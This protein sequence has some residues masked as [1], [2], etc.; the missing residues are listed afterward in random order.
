MASYRKW[1]A[2][3]NSAADEYEKTVRWME[4]AL[5]PPTLEWM[6]ATGRKALIANV[7]R[8]LG[9]K[10]RS[11]AECER[12]AASDKAMAFPPE[13]DMTRGPSALV[14]DADVAAP[15]PGFNRL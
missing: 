1:R 6:S 10:I 4:Q 14:I 13:R 15:I 2:C 7:E 12:D 9:R 3:Y 11:A 8:V 5:L